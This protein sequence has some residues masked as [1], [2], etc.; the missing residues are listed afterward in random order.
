MREAWL[1]AP[2]KRL[3]AKGLMTLLCIANLLVPFSVDIYTPSLPDMPTYFGTSEGMVGLTLALF[4]LVFAGALLVFGA[5]SDGIGSKKI[6]VFG[7]LVYTLGSIACAC[8]TSI[9]FLIAA[10]IVQAIGAGAVYAMATALVSDCFTKEKRGIV[11]TAMQVLFV[12]GP[13]VAPLAGGAIILF[14]TWREVFAVLA[15]LGT[16]C[17]VGSFLYDERPRHSDGPAATL[18]ASLSG[19]LPVFKSKKFMLV[20]MVMSLFNMAFMAYVAAGAYIY[21][22]VRS[23]KHSRHLRSFLP[24]QRQWRLLV[25]SHSRNAERRLMPGISLSFR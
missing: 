23:N 16:A 19:L 5:I 24:E 7:S 21:T 3:G 15:A 20:L 25:R 12:I 14:G 2:Q 18:T 4:Y 10:R 13:I 8:A 9:V 6:L 1:S 17:L 11:L 22:S